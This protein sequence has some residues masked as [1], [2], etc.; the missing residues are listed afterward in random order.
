MPKTH[1]FVGTEKGAFVLSS[2]KRR[3]DWKLHG[4]FLKGW[5]VQDI[6]VDSRGGSPTLWA[7]V[8]SF[9]Y[10]ACV[11]KS[12]DLGRTWE[13]LEAAPHYDEGAPGKLRALWTVTPGHPSRPEE[14]YA[15]VADAGLFR[16]NDSGQSWQELKGV[17]EHPT[18]AEWM[19][20]AGG[21]CCHTIIVHPDNPKR[22]WVGISAVGVFRT[23]DD[24][25]TWDLCNT[26]LDIVLEAKENKHIGS[27]V[28][29]MV[30]DPENPD[31]LYQQNHR[32]LFRSTNGGD[33]W[34]RIEE[35]LPAEN[36]FGFPIALDPTNPDRVFI[37]PEESDEYRMALEGRLT[38]YR[39]EDGGDS[40]Q[41]RRKGLPRDFYSGVLRQA[42]DTDSHDPC[43]V[44]FGTIAG[45][46][47]FSIDAG[48]T[49]D[50]MPYQFP[51][52][53]SVAAW[54]ED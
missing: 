10:A 53:C 50:T 39:T 27:C 49:W 3:T 45:T 34:K 22:V 2:R 28:H 21:L 51:R 47:H 24:G 52:I 46:M 23:D 41:P 42:M 31:R 16:S 36:C 9:V 30:L 29:R 18:R 14:L 25:Q 15:G 40:W 26:G 13:Q 44:Y 48:D 37:V 11:Q 20:G 1:L 43:G 8:G 5:K 12:E 19:P 4:P 54:T 6:R 38:V 35:G 17:S 33:S 32:G 7:A